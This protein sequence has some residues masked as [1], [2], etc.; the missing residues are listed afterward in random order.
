MG[1]FNNFFKQKTSNNYSSNDINI[2]TLNA[3]RL[4]EIINESLTIANESNNPE[5]KIS[6]LGVAKDN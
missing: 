2:V 4:V 6:R 3:K 1:F 5:T